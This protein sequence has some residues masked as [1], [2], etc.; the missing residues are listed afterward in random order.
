MRTT[1]DTVS[2]PVQPISKWC[3]T[4]LSTKA[5]SEN[6]P[7]SLRS[8]GA[9]GRLEHPTHSR[10]VL[11]GRHQHFSPVSCVLWLSAVLGAHGFGL[12]SWRGALRTSVYIPQKHHTMEQALTRETGVALHRG[13]AQLR[14]HGQCVH[15]RARVERQCEQ[16]ALSKRFLYLLQRATQKLASCLAERF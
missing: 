14:K 2:P 15:W 13:S 1:K 8:R 4:G 5:A 10:R 16:H 11:Q 9:R 6:I 7:V 12:W 3:T